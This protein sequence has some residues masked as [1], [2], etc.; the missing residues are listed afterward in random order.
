M[1]VTASLTPPALSVLRVVPLAMLFAMAG[2][3]PVFASG[4]EAAT[5]AA[6]ALTEGRG[7]PVCGAYLM[8]LNRVGSGKLPYC[9][10]PEDSEVAGFALLH[11]VPLTIDEAFALGDRIHNLMQQGNQDSFT[12]NTSYV[13][14]E[15]LRRSLGRSIFAWRYDPLVD[16]DNDG[17]PDRIIVWQGY[18]ASHGNYVCGFVKNREP[19]RQNQ[20]A[21]VIERNGARIDEKRTRE[22][23]GH[24]NQQ[25]G[26]ETNS[27]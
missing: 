12:N 21:F 17:T 7:V 13:T 8:R 11:R 3:Q 19:W 5:G 25:K 24:P 15:L 16:I 27:F 26:S 14:K 22:I 6:F 2:A 23:F 1:K 20:I 18:G 10:R 4:P 9:D